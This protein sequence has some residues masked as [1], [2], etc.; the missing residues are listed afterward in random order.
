MARH[1]R[2][3]RQR[4]ACCS[5]MKLTAIWL[6]GQVSG[7]VGPIDPP[8]AFAPSPHYLMQVLSAVKA[9]SADACVG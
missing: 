4:T 8:R 9:V 3:G 7:F 1:T 5:P 6:V 2:P